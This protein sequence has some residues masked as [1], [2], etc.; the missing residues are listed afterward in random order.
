MNQGTDPIS[1]LC[2]SSPSISAHGNE[3]IIRANDAICVG[4]LVVALGVPTCLNVPY[5]KEPV[6]LLE[7]YTQRFADADR[8]P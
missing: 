3:L 4:R 2:L 8:V 5:S 7:D 1:H 6:S